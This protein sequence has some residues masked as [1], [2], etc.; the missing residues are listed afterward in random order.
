[1]PAGKSMTNSSVS[2]RAKCD[3][4]SLSQQ[5]LVVTLWDTRSGRYLLFPSTQRIH[6][7]TSVNVSGFA[8]FHLDMTRI[9]HLLGSCL[10][11][12]WR[13][14][15]LVCVISCG[16]FIQKALRIFLTDIGIEEPDHGRGR[17][18]G[19]H[20]APLPLKLRASRSARDERFDLPDPCR[21]LPSTSSW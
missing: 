7:W 1:M 13:G 5:G 6:S 9:P 18:P 21:S 4:W 20:S 14:G 19:A 10:R 2:G 12:V 3:S 11:F 15:G 16:R 8:F 17:L